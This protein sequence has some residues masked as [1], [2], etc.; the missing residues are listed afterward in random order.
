MNDAAGLTDAITRIYDRC[1][2]GDVEA[3]AMAAFRAARL[4]NDH[5][6]AAYFMRELFP[7]REEVSGLLAEDMHGLGREA[8]R[9]VW[10]KSFDRWLEVHT[11]D[12]VFPSDPR[13]GDPG[14]R[15]NVLAIAAGE[16]EGEIASWTASMQQLAPPAGMSAFDTAAF[17]AAAAGQRGDI[18][19][20][21]MALNSIKSRLKT[22]CFSY[23]LRIERQLRL[24]T[25]NTS[26]LFEVQNE[27]NNFFSDRSEDVY[28]K[29]LKAAE[30]ASA[31]GED[32]ALLLT[33]V[34]RI[35]KAVADHFRPA[36]P[37][38]VVCSDGRSRIL[39]EEQYMNR[40]EEHLCS[41]LRSST[42]KE[43]V[44][45]ELRLLATFLRRLNDLASKGV[46]ASVAAA[47]ARQGF[48]GLYMFLFSVCQHA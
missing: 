42:A 40:L 48:V 12:N 8:L 3:A 23:A 46:H 6:G 20:R 13:R 4:S 37:E 27:V 26:I 7:K 11:M 19:L 33:E 44:L 30:L 34:R 39:G 2:A 45:A 18:Q 22:R 14:D 21:L 1:E 16:I 35:L 17:A 32:A 9:F 43:L 15:R 29:L 47:E 31:S 38:P 36:S 28:G 25:R 41:A 24:Q 5:L 10:E